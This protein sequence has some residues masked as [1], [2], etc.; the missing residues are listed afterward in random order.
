MSRID[1]GDAE[2]KHTHSCSALGKGWKEREEREREA[3][4]FKLEKEGKR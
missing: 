3:I 4:I 2:S 1:L